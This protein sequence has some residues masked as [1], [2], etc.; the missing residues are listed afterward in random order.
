[1]AEPDEPR[2]RIVSYEDD[3]HRF[4]AVLNRSPE[5]DRLTAREVEAK[6]NEWRRTHRHL[7]AVD[8]PE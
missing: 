3:D 7:K 4:I 8:D 1:M 5:T 2:T 6:L